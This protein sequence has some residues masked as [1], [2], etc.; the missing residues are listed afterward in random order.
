LSW[1]DIAQAAEAAARDPAQL[2]TFTNTM[3]GEPFAEPHDA[4]DW[5]RLRERQTDAALGVVPAG[6]LFLTAGVDIQ[7]DRIEASIWG[8]GRGR[9]AWLVDHQVLEGDTA[10]DVPW[11]ALSALVARTWPTADGAHALVLAKVG[12]DTGFATTQVHTW[13][14]PQAP[15]RVVLLKGG[16]PAVA[17]VSLPRSAEAIETT[18]R[19]RRRRRCM[20]VYLVHVGAYKAE[21]YGSLRLDGPA[22]GL[23][24]PPGWVSL[25]AVGDEFLRQLTAE[26]LVR[27]VVRGIERLEWVKVYNRNE[28]LDCHTMARAAAHLV[29]LDR[30]Q[31]ADC[32]RSRRRA[33][34][35]RRRRSRHRTRHR[36]ARRRPPPPRSPRPPRRR[37]CRRRCDRGAGHVA[38]VTLLGPRRRE[39]A[40]ARRRRSRQTSRSAST[41][42]S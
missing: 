38:A 20:R 33:G 25:P 13:A 8:W 36:A 30:F 10:G 32:R 16:P 15:N 35:R 26:A 6:A 9:R 37:S 18:G 27:K 42:C 2:K 28:A 5:H 11:A 12:V 19:L 39:L 24:A 14:A 17:V 3:L 21:L 40:V 34:S 4:P 23:P 22:P 1:A 31:E 7:R 29:G 41:R